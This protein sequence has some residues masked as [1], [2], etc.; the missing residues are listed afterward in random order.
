[1]KGTRLAGR[2]LLRLSRVRLDLVAMLIWRHLWRRLMPESCSAT[3]LYLWADASPQKRGIELFAASVDVLSGY[4][5]RRWLLPVIGLPRIA[6]DHVGKT[7]ALLWMVVLITGPSP[8]AIRSFLSR[9]RCT[10]SDM[11]TGRLMVDMPDCLQDL[12]WYLGWR[13][14]PLEELPWLFPRALQM[15]G[16]MLTPM[17]R[18]FLQTS[19]RL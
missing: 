16:W 19:L 5:S 3:N 10:T 1:M 8:R 18:Q 12:F 7:L 9:A 14:G 2:E 15:P 13:A 4:L 11:G 17:V 6:L